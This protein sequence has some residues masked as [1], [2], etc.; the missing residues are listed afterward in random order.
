MTAARMP[1]PR[2]LVAGTS[3]T[4]IVAALLFQQ[5]F[6]PAAWM[7]YR[8]FDVRGARNFINYLS[9]GV[10]DVSSGTSYQFKQPRTG[11]LLAV[12]FGFFPLML[13]LRIA[14]DLDFK[15]RVRRW[16]TQW[17][18]FVVA[19]LGV[20]R[21]AGVCPVKRTSL[22]VFPFVN[23]QACELA[24]GACPL[25]TFQMSLLH[26]QAPLLVIG[27]IALAG[28]LTGRL[29]CGWLCP[30]GFLSDIFEKLPHRERVR[31]RPAW[32]HVR[33]VVLAIFLAASLAALFRDRSEPLLYCSYLCPAGF[34]YGVL[35]Y[36]LTT[37]LVSV[38]ARLP[39]VHFMLVY[40]FA[41]G[42]AV[43]FGSIKLGG[44]FWCKYGCPLGTLLGFFSS[45]ALLRVA[46]MQGR[47][48]GC[49]GC[50]KVCPMG[51]NPLNEGFLSKSLCIVCGRCVRAC[52]TGRIRFKVG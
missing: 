23:C 13:A 47:C 4:L 9:P 11:L 10:K 50:R 24:T 8:D 40:H 16:L 36:A 18:G 20:L 31:P 32:I 39:L 35:E 19:R 46:S 43:I 37:G 49:G 26:G 1:D 41:V 17:A 34:F 38:R 14:F 29:V 12:L 45:H 2:L 28:I 3:L 52:P 30:Y 5:A 33:Y 42:A 22:G 15:L 51:I 7:T 48:N 44:R 25:G 21:V 27:E 6:R